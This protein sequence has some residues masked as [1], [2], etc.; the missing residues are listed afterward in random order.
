MGRKHIHSCYHISG[1][2]FFFCWFFYFFLSGLHN[3]TRKSVKSDVR[4]MNMV[5]SVQWLLKYDVCCTT[6]KRQ[7]SGKYAFST[8]NLISEIR[9][10]RNKRG[11]EFVY[12]VSK[13]VCNSVLT[14]F[15]GEHGTVQIMRQIETLFFLCEKILEIFS[16]STE[17][18]QWKC[19]GK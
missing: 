10:E 6:S 11:F 12:P 16:L 4:R 2:S 8:R 3:K 18:T 9:L 5:F 1:Y 15:V 17:R 14:C 13:N 7:K 19:F